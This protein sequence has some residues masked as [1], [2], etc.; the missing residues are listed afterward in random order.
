MRITQEADYALRIVYFLAIQNMTIDAGTIAKEIS[1]P[2]RFSLKILRKLML[3]EIVRSRKGAS[4]GYFLSLPLSEITVLRVIECIDG[5]L[6][7]NK[8]LHNENVCNGGTEKGN[9]YFHNLF[10]EL[11]RYVVDKLGNITFADVIQHYKE[12]SDVKNYI[13]MRT[14]DELCPKNE[15]RN[16][17][18]LKNS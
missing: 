17:D 2:Q 10:Y 14:K 7:M 1:I 4:G 13:M 5:P 15:I 8:C 12:T 18:S 11:N 6:Y 16:L 9:C 3:N